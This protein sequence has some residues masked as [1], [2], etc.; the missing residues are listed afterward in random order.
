MD[1]P[2]YFFVARAIRQR[3]PKLLK[4][5]GEDLP[6]IIG[7]DVEKPT[8]LPPSKDSFFVNA[9]GKDIATKFFEQY[10]MLYDSDRS[11]IAAAYHENGVFS[12]VAAKADYIRGATLANYLHRS[13]NLVIVKDRE[14]RAK[15]LQTGVSDITTFLTKLPK[16]RHDASSMFL[17]VV[18][19]TPNFISVTICGI[20]K[21][22]E[23]NNSGADVFRAFSRSC[24]IVPY[25]DGFK[26]VN[27]MLLITIPTSDMRN[28]AFKNVVVPA[29]LPVPSVTA[30]PSSQNLMPLLSAD[31]DSIKQQMILSFSQQSGMNLDW[32]RRCL[33]DLN[34]D[35][36]RAAQAFTE[37]NANGGIPPEAWATN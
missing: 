12:L 32:S 23:T 20:F 2:K 35:F 34:W 30:S 33:V 9:K 21:E 29:P 36:G 16:T 28:Q 10:F 19:C 5:D 1:L 15:Y 4:L 18:A 8:T 17:D 7:F 37:L 25:A 3:F 13:R 24:I 31:D 26:L 22:L 27:D 14:R 11:S 6:P